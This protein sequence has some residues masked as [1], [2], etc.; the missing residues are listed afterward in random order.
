MTLA[1]SPRSSLKRSPSPS[2]TPTRPNTITPRGAH[3]KRRPVFLDRRHGVGHPVGAHLARAV[4]E[5]A[6][7]RPYTGAHYQRL[8]VEVPLA[9][10]FEY[11]L[12]VG[13]EAAD[14]GM[15]AAG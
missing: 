2:P 3:A 8:H 6:Q 5:D 11:R 12:Q 7:P 15:P 4:I 1:S 10:A 14:D 9:D 13:D